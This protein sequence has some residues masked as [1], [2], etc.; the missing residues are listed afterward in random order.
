MPTSDIVQTWRTQGAPAGWQALDEAPDD[1]DR[2]DFIAVKKRGRG[3]VSSVG[4]SAPPADSAD[5]ERATASYFARTGRGTRLRMS[6]VAGGET[7]TRAKMPARSLPRWRSVAF[8]LP[9]GAAD[10]NLR[11]RFAANGRTAKVSAA[12][13]K[14]RT[15]Q[16]QVFDSLSTL[17]PGRPLPVGGTGSANLTAA[18]NE[19]ESFQVSITAGSKA[20]TGVTVAAA[21]P[22]QGPG[23]AEISTSNLTVY[24][25]ATYTVKQASDYEGAEGAWADPLIPE[26]DY[27]YGEDRN[28]FPVKVPAGNREVAWIDVAVP[29]GQSPGTYEGSLRVQGDGGAV[30]DVPVKLTVL[31]LTLPATS[32]LRTSFA[33]EPDT[34]CRVH[35]PGVTSCGP[36][37][38]GAGGWDRSWQLHALYARAGLEN[39]VTISNPFPLGKNSAPS[40]I[41]NGE[42]LF[43]KYIL[44]LLTGDG[45]GPD[46]LRPRVAGASLTAVSLLRECADAPPCLSQWRDLA[47]RN[48]LTD[49]FL[50]YVCDEPED[51]SADWA[52]CGTSAAAFDRHWP[53]LKKLVT[54]TKRDAVDF[55]GTVGG[56]PMLS[57]LD[58][59]VPPVYWL[60]DRPGARFEG[61]QR[62]GYDSFLDG[63]DNE[64]WSYNACGSHGCTTAQTASNWNSDYWK[65]WPGYVID[66]PA[67]YER[68]M[69]WLAYEYD[70]DG[71]LYFNTTRKLGAAWT[72]SF[73]YGGNGDGTLFYPGWAA[74]Q[75]GTPG[76]GDTGEVGGTHDIPIESI[77]LK[78]IRDS[79]EDHEY[80]RL[81]EQ[82]GQGEEAQAIALSVFGPTLDVATYNTAVTPGELNNARCRLASALD[83]VNGVECSG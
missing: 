22:L 68:A 40:A 73:D 11:L 48:G 64:L 67:S 24:R 7:L 66:Q 72:D 30:A 52:K 37:A 28:A 19:F 54:A 9:I 4:I 80:M 83:P 5:A 21:G 59:L 31:D 23:D 63:T 76:D 25:E 10:D 55:G 6:V 74:G 3:R 43:N 58:I 51:S 53:D 65:G 29:A 79:Q 35:T 38:G 17:R 81:L 49:R 60:S 32:T 75:N 13:V 71:E 45:S 56:A 70:L 44:P 42:A 50:G 62:P 15:S 46:Y 57:A 2:S 18:G 78:R 16:V 12:N 36:N 34:P 39:R 69:G 26:T 47:S 27:F 8:D 77:R 41:P 14:L 33:I 20:L 82:R 61:N 1:L